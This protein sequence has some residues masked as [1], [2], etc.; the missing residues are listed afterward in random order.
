MMG[1]MGLGNMYGLMV[2][3]MKGNGRIVKC[4]GKGNRL[5]KMARNM[6]ACLIMV[7]KMDLECLFGQGKVNMKAIGKQGSRM[8]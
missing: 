8:V 2:I 6:K 5:G 4:T 1:S 3:F 7:T